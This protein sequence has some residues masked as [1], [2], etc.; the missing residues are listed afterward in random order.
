MNKKGF[1][2]IELLGVIALIAILSVLIVP[3]IMNVNKNMNSRL[4]T[5]KKENIIA[6]AELY[7]SNNPDIFKGSDTV[8]ITVL[9]LLES[10]YLKPDSYD[11]EKC[12]EE[13]TKAGCVIDSRNDATKKSMNDMKITLTKEMVGITA[14][15]EEITEIASNSDTL[16]NKVC[17]GF[18]LGT[19][20]G[21]FGTGLS[22]SI[23]QVQLSSAPVPNLPP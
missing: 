16:V 21:K 14:K 3:N 2:L 20:G 9:D 18:R 8:T 7:G 23:L 4:Y 10:D 13:T 6:A 15:F 11:K 12:G 17:E 19:Y 5:K 22:F 1:T